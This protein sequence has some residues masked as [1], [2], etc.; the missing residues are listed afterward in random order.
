VRWRLVIYVALFNL[1]VSCSGTI[2]KIGL[3]FTEGLSDGII[4]AS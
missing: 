3:L 2:V 4:I 1:D